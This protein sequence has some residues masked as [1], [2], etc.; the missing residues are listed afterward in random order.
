LISQSNVT[1]PR[2]TGNA[3]LKTVDVPR[4]IGG[5]ESY[6]ITYIFHIY[7]LLQN[8]ILFSEIRIIS[9]SSIL[10]SQASIKNAVKNGYI[11]LSR[12]LLRFQLPPNYR[13]LHD[14]RAKPE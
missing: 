8:F 5:K 14:S 10:S 1:K 9:D 3:K 7:L 11:L 12:G 2:S 13:G 4:L 6:Q